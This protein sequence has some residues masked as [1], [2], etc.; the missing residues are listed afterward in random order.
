MTGAFGDM[1]LSATRVDEESEVGGVKYKTIGIRANGSADVPMPDKAALEN[2]LTSA[3][4]D[5]SDSD[6]VAYHLN[7]CQNQV[8]RGAVPAAID[9][10]VTIAIIEGPDA[11]VFITRTF[12]EESAAAGGR[13][14]IDSFP[15]LTCRVE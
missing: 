12:K 6:I 1:R 3:G 14:K 5:P 9:A 13:M 10:D 8:A 2:C 11:E 15:P 4:A 7:V